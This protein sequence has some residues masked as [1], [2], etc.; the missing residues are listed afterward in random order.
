MGFRVRV[1]VI[2]VRVRVRVTV[3]FGLGGASVAYR[4]LH[5]ACA[6]VDRLVHPLH[7]VI[8]VQV[9]QRTRST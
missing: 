7:E 5:V 6:R 8:G 2:G 4:S 3:G 1:R 9:T